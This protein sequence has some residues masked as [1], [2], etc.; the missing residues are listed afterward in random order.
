M[1]RK[2]L[3]FLFFLVSIA[4]ICITYHTNKNHTF[5]EEFEEFIS[6]PIQIP[7]DKFERKICYAFQDNLKEENKLRLIFYIDSIGCVDCKI[8]RTL[9][10]AKL[11]K[12][13]CTKVRF[14]YIFPVKNPDSEALFRRLCLQ[15]VEGEVY[16]DTCNAF[17]NA[18]P[19]FP[20]NRRIFHTFALDNKN[21][22]IFAGN[23][24][25][26]PKNEE[27]FKKIVKVYTSKNRTDT[28]C[29]SKM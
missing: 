1:K 13:I 29:T 24:T 8:L 20:L 18:N 5:R 25:Y 26:N 6:T 11:N 15:R 23:P 2:T 12:D 28:Q 22:V 3:I 21:N 10:F 17:K 19:K 4:V 27:V 14:I 9:S 16:F 7:Y